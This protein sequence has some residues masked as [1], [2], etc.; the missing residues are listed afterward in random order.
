MEIKLLSGGKEETVLSG[1]SLSPCD[2]Q[3]IRVSSLVSQ[4][5]SIAVPS[6]PLEPKLLAHT[7]RQGKGRAFLALDL[8][9]FLWFFNVNHDLATYF[10]F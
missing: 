6:R 4:T 8:K 9:W 2:P 5:T 1:F 10:F 3:S 7:D